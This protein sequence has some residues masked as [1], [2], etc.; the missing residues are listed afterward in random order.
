MSQ[1]STPAPGW[2]CVLL[3][4]AHAGNPAAWHRSDDLRP[5]SR[6]GWLQ[7]SDVVGALS[8]LRLRSLLTSPASRCRQTLLPLS[9]TLSLEVEPRA[10]LSLK[11]D[12]E[13]LVAL[14]SSPESDG[15]VVCTHGEVIEDVLDRWPGMNG[16]RRE[17][18]AKGG[19]WII[20]GSDGAPVDLTYVA[21]LRAE[22]APQP[23][24][25]AA[26]G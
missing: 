4:H 13:H 26:S 23:D 5:L 10:E 19:C 12:R 7:A 16:H 18:T 24:E 9:N 8:G 6:L 22:K 14:L 17:P 11:G 15:M 1:H 20:S 21:P 3:R 2:T 25:V